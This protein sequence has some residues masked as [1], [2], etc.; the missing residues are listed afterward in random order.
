MMM[1]CTGFIQGQTYY[2]DS[3]GGSDTAN[4]RSE[5][6]AW[7]TF[8]NLNATIFDAGDSILLKRGSVWTNS[9][10]FPKGSGSAGSPV[11]L[12]TYGT[13]AK[14]QINGSGTQLA[15]LILLNQEYWD[16]EEIELTNWATSN[17]S[18]KRYGAYVLLNDYGTSRHI[19]LR[20]LVIHD[21]NGNPASKECGAIF[22]EVI[23]NSTPS[24][25]DSLIVEGCDIYD[26]G[27]IAIGNTSSW[28]SRT[29]T[30]NSTWF[31]ST[32]IYWRNN[33]IRRT[34]RNGIIVRVARR[35][36]LEYNI[37]QECAKDSSGNAMF[38][39]NCDSAT[40]Q[41]NEA[42][43]TRY[44]DGDVD[45]GGFDADY[46]CKKTIIQY[47]YSHDNEY[48]GIVIV[49]DGSG[50]STFN[51]SAIVRYNILRD[52]L[53]HGIRVSGN[54][55]NALIY[56]NTL[57]SGTDA[58]AVTVLWH[59]SWGGYP[60]RTSY[61]NNIFEA[62]KRGSLYDLGNSTN[63]LFDYNVFHGFASG[64][65]SDAHKLN[66]DPLFVA[67][68]SAQTG[69]STA[70]GLRLQP[71]SP[72]INSGVAITG[73]QNIDYC[74]N[75]VPSGSAIDRGAIEYQETDGVNP[76]FMNLPE[77]W[78]IED[79]FPNPFNPVTTIRITVPER[80]HVSVSVM[81]ILGIEVANLLSGQVSPGTIS[82]QFDGTNLPSG[83]YFVK[84]S[85]D[86]FS[87]TK[88]VFLVR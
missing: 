24:W 45:A 20:N 74:G 52:N 50:T 1:L 46:R 43:L 38:A 58:G 65:P 54:V 49:S 5:S 4:G 69:W 2:I 18:A 75:H 37:L 53:R 47:N 29:L 56:N 32:N 41:Y 71:T 59:K 78:K 66:S 72:A 21:V 16:I 85:T 17:L 76:E 81:S 87:Q 79:A 8:A 82:L 84:V 3:E 61:Y 9:S 83:I 60:D 42:F 44:N 27:P 48:G 30:V 86:R 51:D 40:M 11:I 62:K 63:N 73:G 6:H 14:P 55:S 13:G 57:Y 19:R 22:F 23:G 77:Q 28:A 35:P 70:F 80:Q 34:V 12:S 7:K 36:I 25:Y 68:D 10:I 39:F 15:A 33:T 88:R 26:V 31:P 67:A 64:E